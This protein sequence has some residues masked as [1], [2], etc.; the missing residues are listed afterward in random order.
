MWI[1]QRLEKW[2]FGHFGVIFIMPEPPGSVDFR[3]GVRFHKPLSHHQISTDLSYP[4]PLPV[5]LE[6]A[7]IVPLSGN[8]AIWSRQQRRSPIAAA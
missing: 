8:N 2:R 1:V 6:R 3:S 7:E 5:N 4:Q